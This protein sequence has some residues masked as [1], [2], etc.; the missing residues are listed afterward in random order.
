[1]F[2][3]FVFLCGIESTTYFQSWRAV[4]R[5]LLSLCVHHNLSGWM[6]GRAVKVL[7]SP[8]RR[9]ESNLKRRHPLAARIATASLIKIQRL[10]FLFPCRN[11][12]GRHWHHYFHYSVL[13]SFK[14][15]FKKRE[16]ERKND[17]N[18]GRLVCSVSAV[19][20][21]YVLHIYTTV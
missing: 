16:T 21:R 8:L 4:Y 1:M 19:K 5:L 3:F 13:C 10:H 9:A 15:R 14:N 17:E 11:H 2:I 6:N 12:S 18:N 7:F 20:S